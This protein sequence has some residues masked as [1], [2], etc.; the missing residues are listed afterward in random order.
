[1]RYLVLLLALAGCAPPQ[2]AG[3]PIQQHR[4]QQIR[5]ALARVEDSIE[6]LERLEEAAGGV[7]ALFPNIQRDYA[8]ALEEARWKADELKQQLRALDGE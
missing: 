1:M 6:H 3:C 7:L 4:E 5:V 8:R 2:P